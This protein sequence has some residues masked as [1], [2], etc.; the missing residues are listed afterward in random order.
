MGYSM[1]RRPAFTLVEALVVIAIIGV[2]VAL[3]MPAVQRIRDHASRM[4]CR[5]NL[6]QIGLALHHHHERFKR[7]PA[8]YA[9]KSPTVDGPNLGPG[10]GWAAA[11]LP[12][13]EQVAV[14]NQIDFRKDISDP[15]NAVPRRTPLAIF[16][17]PTDQPPTTT[18]TAT[19]AGG[20]A[21][22]DVAFSNYVAIAGVNEVSIFP[23]TSNGEPGV[24]LRNSRTRVADIR[25]GTSMTVIVTERCWPRSPQTTWVGAVTGSSVPPINP[26]YD[27]E[28]A[29][30][31][32]LTNS[33]TIADARLPNNSFM[34]V[35]DAGSLHPAGVPIL[36]ADGAVR[37]LLYG[38]E[39]WLWVALV[40]RSGGEIISTEFY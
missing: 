31:L 10:W 11:I 30:V 28:A 26:A 29:G 14:Y 34:H 9:S 36:F 19:D 20:A 6:K 24:F 25:D 17:C 40:T 1:R 8:G 35:E 3:L 32:C 18:F 15:A 7:F 38:S 22:C 39:P 27:D 33:G 4:H 16:L 5:N 2:I 37:S 12:D 21:I 23:D 13:L